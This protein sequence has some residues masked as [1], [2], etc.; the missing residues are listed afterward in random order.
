MQRI[1]DW[2]RLSDR[3][4]NFGATVFREDGSAASVVVSD[5]SFEGC[6][7]RSDVIFSPGER[8]RLY[9][10]GQGCILMTATHC[11]GKSVRAMF[12]TD[13]QV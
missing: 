9:Q 8:L 10:R 2:S 1:I 6:S 3:R 7:L 13:C 11:S 12:V 5:F 4:A